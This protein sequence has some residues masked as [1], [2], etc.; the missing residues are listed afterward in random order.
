[1]NTRI[2]PLSKQSA[3]PADH[4]ARQRGVRVI[5]EGSEAEARGRSR[6][7]LG[8]LAQ[9]GRKQPDRGRTG[10]EMRVA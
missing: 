5:G 8:A 6:V 1:M 10:G 4:I 7:P 2:S 9:L 3:R